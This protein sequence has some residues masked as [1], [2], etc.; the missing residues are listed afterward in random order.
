[1]KLNH[2]TK[3]S[4]DMTFSKIVV[5]PSAGTYI[6]DFLPELHRLANKYKCEVSATFNGT[7]ILIKPQNND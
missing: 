3:E 5:T 2:K 7:E 4:K 1:M 6:G